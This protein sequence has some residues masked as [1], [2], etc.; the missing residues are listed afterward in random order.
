MKY[1]QLKMI[2]FKRRNQS[3]ARPDDDM[4]ITAQNQVGVEASFCSLTLLSVN[5]SVGKQLMGLRLCDDDNIIIMH[6][7]AVVGREAL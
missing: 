7:A 1:T 5:Y 4:G 6:A 2:Y 3:S